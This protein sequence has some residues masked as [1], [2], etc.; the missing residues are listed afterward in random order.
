MNFFRRA[1]RWS[2]AIATAAY[3]LDISRYNQESLYDEY[4][5]PK[6]FQYYLTYNLSRFPPEYIKPWMYDHFVGHWFLRNTLFKVF[7]GGE[8]IDDLRATMIKL[9]Q[10]NIGTIADYSVEQD[11]VLIDSIQ[12]RNR[13]HILADTHGE[14]LKSS[15]LGDFSAIKL[16][17]L[18][19]TIALKRVTNLILDIEKKHGKQEL[20]R[21]F[22]SEES[23]KY[24]NEKIECSERDLLDFK[25]I[26]HRVQDIIDYA[27][28]HRTQV[29]IDAEQSYYQPAIS[30]ISMLLA[31]EYNHEK[32]VVL[33]TFQMYLKRGIHDLKESL[34]FAE[35]EKFL[36]GCK[37]VRGAYMVSE[38]KRALE[39]SYD[40]PIHDNI[41][42]TH[43]D[44][45]SAINILHNYVQKKPTSTHIIASHNKQS[46]ILAQ[47]LFKDFKKSAVLGQLLGMH[48]TMTFNNAKQ[49][50]RAYKYVVYIYIGSIWATGIGCALFD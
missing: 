6:L 4:Q 13:Q 25:R 7:C 23:D 34:E 16:T 9:Q 20:L 31:K 2:P 3:M 33:P 32:S 11:D 19:P 1:V 45:D 29:T 10:L 43:K 27:S 28:Q 21:I 44:F 30:V 8:K 47:K 35:K 17:A 36:F 50:Y 15:C 41:E 49:N 38:R 48:D 37:I 40:S 12:E 14:V 18:G 46:M 24:L 42:N 39:M 5:W 26:Y 22:E